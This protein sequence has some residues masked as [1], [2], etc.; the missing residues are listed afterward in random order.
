MTY[1]QVPDDGFGF[2]DVESALVQ[3]LDTELL[4][5]LT[6]T[7]GYACVTPPPNLDQ[8]IDEGQAVVTVQRSGGTLID[9]NQEAARV[10]IGVTTATRSA[11]WEVFGWLRAHLHEYRGYVQLPTGVT[12]RVQSISD[13]QGPQKDPALSQDA[14]RVGG[15]FVVTVKKY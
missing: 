2:P 13:M 4:P 3:L 11:S 6:P 1:P 5:Q 9:R 14:R 7:G 15:G 10:F 12:V 8:L